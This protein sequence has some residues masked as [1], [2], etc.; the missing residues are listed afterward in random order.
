MVVPFELA[1]CTLD[2]FSRRC[3]LLIN[4]VHLIAF[5]YLIVYIDRNVIECDYICFDY[6]S[7]FE[8]GFFFLTSM[9]RVLP[10]YLHMLNNSLL[11]ELSTFNAKHLT[12]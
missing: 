10:Y 1:H 7:N 2:R 8:W 11:I 6:V 5:Y 4:Y 9:K 3:I 12:M